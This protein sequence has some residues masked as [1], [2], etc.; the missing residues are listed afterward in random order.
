MKNLFISI[1]ATSKETLHAENAGFI[2]EFLRKVHEVDRR[3]ESLT[4]K[5][6]G[7]LGDLASAYGKTIADKLRE[8]WIDNF[9]KYSRATSNPETKKMAKYAK[10]VFFCT[11][12]YFVNVFF[13]LLLQ[14]PY[15]K[16]QHGKN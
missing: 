7:L 3:P 9:I 4:S 11:K 10:E 13:T 8:N 6:V 16:Q 14:R 1:V 15:E 12:T 2:F 5:A